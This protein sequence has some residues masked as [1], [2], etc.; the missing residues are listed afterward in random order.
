MQDKTS[1]CLIGRGF[2]MMLEDSYK[3]GRRCYEDYSAG[4]GPSCVRVLDL[5]EFNNYS[6]IKQSNNPEF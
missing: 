2:I 4:W 6:L 5:M 3:T 1:H